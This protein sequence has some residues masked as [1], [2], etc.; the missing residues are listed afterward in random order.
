MRSLYASGT[1]HGLDRDCKSPEVRGR[2]SGQ[3]GQS[4]L[5]QGKEG[6]TV[7]ND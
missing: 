1:S 7:G 4:N 6:M 2:R 5:R 3:S